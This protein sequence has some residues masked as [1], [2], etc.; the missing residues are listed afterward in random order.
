LCGAQIKAAD[1]IMMLGTTARETSNGYDK[2]RENLKYN[3]SALQ[4]GAAVARPTK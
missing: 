2:G 1:A 4:H 3:L